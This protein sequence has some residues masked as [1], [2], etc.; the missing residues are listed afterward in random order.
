MLGWICIAMTVAA[1]VMRFAMRFET[2]V[3]ETLMDRYIDVSLVGMLSLPFLL[4]AN[5]ARI[6][7]IPKIDMA[8]LRMAMEAAFTPVE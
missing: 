6:L 2:P 7:N 1:T 5:F 3:K 8:Q 4:I